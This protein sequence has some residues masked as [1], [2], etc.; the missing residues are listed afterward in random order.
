[1]KKAVVLLLVIMSLWQARPM[2]GSAGTEG[3]SF[4]D[5]PVGAAPA[6]MGGAYSALASDVYAPIYNPAG[7]GRLDHTELGTQHS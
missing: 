1:M 4:L 7:L 5:I 3:A 2:W 6:A